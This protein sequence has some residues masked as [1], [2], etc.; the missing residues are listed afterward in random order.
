M[1]K[2]V[3]EEVVDECVMFFLGVA[4]YGIWKEWWKKMDQWIP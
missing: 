4:V 1:I 3:I 2:Y